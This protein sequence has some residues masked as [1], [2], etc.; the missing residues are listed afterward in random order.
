MS[1]VLPLT[2][3]YLKKVT[4]FFA[5]FCLLDLEPSFSQC[6][7]WTQKADFGGTARQGAF[8][9]VVNGMAYVGAGF[10]KTCNCG[11]K[12]FWEYDPI[13]DSWAQKADYGG[14]ESWYV[15]GFSIGSKGY[16]GTGGDGVNLLPD[17]FEYDPATNNWTQKA[18]F[19]GGDR[20][21]ALGFAVNGS[22]YL[23]TGYDGVTRVK[24]FW[25]YIVSND[26]WV[27]KSDFGGV[28]RN[29]G[30][31]FSIGN[32]GYAGTGFNNSVVELADFWE[33]EPTTDAWTQ[34][35]DVGGPGRVSA[36]GFSICGKGYIGTGDNGGR[37]KDFW[38]YDTLNNSW[39]Q[40]AD[41][42]ST[43]RRYVYG[44]AVG[45]KGYIGGGS[46]SPTLYSR[47]LWEYTPITPIISEDTFTNV[48][49]NGDTTGSI[50][51]DACGYGIL[52]YSIDLGLSYSGNG[53]IFTN[54]S[55]GIYA[56]SVKDSNNCTINGDTIT[57]TEPPALSM[58]SLA[59]PGLILCNGDM[60][61]TLE[62]YASGGTPVLSYSIDS[63]STYSSTSLFDSLAAGSYEILVKDSNN[64][65]VGPSS[66][67]IS[68]P[69][70]L[71]VDNVAITEVMCNG[72]ADGEIVITASGGTGGL[73]YSIDSGATYVSNGGMFLGLSAGNNNL[74]VMDANGCTTNGGSALITEP[75]AMTGN[76]SSTP[77]S[78][79]AVG[80]AT[81]IASGGIGPYQYSWFPG[82]QST[83]AA[84]GLTGNDYIV[85]VTDMDGCTYSDTVNVGT[86]VSLETLNGVN[87]IR[88]YPI[89]SKG[90]LHIEF[91]NMVN[92]KI[93]VY[94]QLGRL[95]SCEIEKVAAGKFRI[96]G[97][98]SGLYIVE[99]R[100]ENTEVNRSIL[101]EE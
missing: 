101:V 30:I 59:A 24:D 36:M 84:T 16:A 11:R 67:N 74:S 49:C 46:V 53:G 94:D 33:Y 97:L 29:A 72:N 70:A 58:D 40:R 57:I 47:D 41:F 56:I 90:Y 43:P 28:A 22:G 82:G 44:F 75:T 69:A 20:T 14:V 92:P 45:G 79:G 73:T 89:P 31:G 96:T 55:A 81:V 6:D 35:T 68:E 32:K 83:A 1:N 21:N 7:S 50:T 15:V 66:V 39:T 27:Q 100:D 37:L 80:T 71:V 25:Q 52:S 17:F 2:P 18:N 42:G 13:A 95:V 9:F 91:D 87:G 78:G 65:I 4:L 23:G 60:T 85:T 76:T 77:D 34:K 12:D 62:V 98:R 61:A 19:G 3:G 51:I 63:G 26:T 5:V 88:I 93:G 64:C 99:I 8:S 10:E 54:L 38:E 48:I 86:Y